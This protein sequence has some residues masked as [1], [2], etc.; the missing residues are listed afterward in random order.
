ML[1]QGPG[2]INQAL[3]DEA[4]GSGAEEGAGRRGEEGRVL[5]VFLSL[6][7]FLVEHEF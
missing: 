2:R 1:V 3:A 5:L 6:C 7:L 4:S